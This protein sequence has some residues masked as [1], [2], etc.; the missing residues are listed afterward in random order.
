MPPSILIPLILQPGA[1]YIIENRRRNIA[2]KAL[3]LIQ[4]GSVH[5][6]LHPHS[7]DDHS[8]GNRKD[9]PSPEEERDLK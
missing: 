8:N 7:Q 5:G 4:L 6:D 2:I 9:D 1:G 3:T